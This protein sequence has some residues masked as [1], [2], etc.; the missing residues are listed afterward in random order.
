MTPDFMAECRA[1]FEEALR[2]VKMSDGKMSF[3]KTFTGRTEKAKVIFKPVAWT[4]M[5]WLIRNF[6]KEVAWHGIAYRG[7]DESKHE[8]YITDILVYPQE[9][10]GAT[11][12]TDQEKYQTWLY[13]LEDEQF[14]N[15]RMQGHSHV[16]MGV[17]PSSVDLTHQAKILEQLEDDMFYIFMIYNKSLQ[18]T[19]KIYDMKKNILFEDSDVAVEVEGDSSLTEF[20][21]SAKEMVVNKTYT[22]GV[23]YNSS[24]AKPAAATA[25]KPAAAASSTATKPT[26][27]SNKTRTT[28]WRFE[29]RT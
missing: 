26:E 4:K 21:K 1:A 18:R 9:V 15:M 20:E 19:V 13:G 2:I 11:V 22:P 28:T 17:T 14:N 24:T 29:P 5:L 6:D 8:Y 23:S 27:E 10:T 16:N 12:N 25:A 3:T 7:Q